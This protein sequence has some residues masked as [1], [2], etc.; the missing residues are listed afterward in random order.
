MLWQGR[1]AAVLASDIKH[2]GQAKAEKEDLLEIPASELD[3]G[4]KRNQDPSGMRLPWLLGFP[5]FLSYLL[6]SH[7]EVWP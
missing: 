2:T 4:P 5:P 6:W 1:C 3:T 7:L